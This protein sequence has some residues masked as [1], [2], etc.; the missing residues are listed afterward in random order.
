MLLNGFRRI[1]LAHSL[2]VEQQPPGM[3]LGAS[4]AGDG[5]T[6]APRQRESEPAPTALDATAGTLKDRAVHM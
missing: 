3:T 5:T 6:L 2:L 4:K 1:A